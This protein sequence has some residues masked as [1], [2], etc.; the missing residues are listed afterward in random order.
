[1]YC[2]T[3]LINLLQH[4]T[5][6]CFPGFF[7]DINLFNSSKERASQIAINSVDMIDNVPDS[8]DISGKGGLA[9]E[10]ANLMIK[11]KFLTYKVH[12]L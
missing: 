4:L 8:N 1:M 3:A 5:Y 10:D 2:Y 11:L 12:V 6:F 7:A 9:D